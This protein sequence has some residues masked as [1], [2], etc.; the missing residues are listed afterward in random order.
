VN[1]LK[2]YKDGR[3]ESRSKWRKIWV[4]TPNSRDSRWAD[5]SIS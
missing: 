3:L 5:Q 1:I 4:S 2:L